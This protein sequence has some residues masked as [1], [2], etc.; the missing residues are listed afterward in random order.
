[1][2]SLFASESYFCDDFSPGIWN[3]FLKMQMPLRRKARWFHDFDTANCS[4]GNG[5]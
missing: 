3:D 1:M 2:I 5:I 4:I